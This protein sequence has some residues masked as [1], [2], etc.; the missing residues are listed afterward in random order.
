MCSSC[1][2]D[3]AVVGEGSVV[4]DLHGWVAVEVELCDGVEDNAVANANHAARAEG[5][6]S[7]ATGVVCFQGEL[8]ASSLGRVSMIL[9]P[10]AEWASLPS[11]WRMD[12]LE[13]VL[14]PTAR[15]RLHPF[16]HF[17]KKG[18]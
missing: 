5:T 12:P 18:V 9:C 11:I 14:E 15:F 7:E 4:A 6:C 2:E 8:F 16:G 10:T 17:Q 1:V 3:G 13:L